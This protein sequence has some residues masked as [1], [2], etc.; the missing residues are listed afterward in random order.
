MESRTYPR[1][2]SAKQEAKET[3]STD[4]STRLHPLPL[5]PITH[6]LQE[7]ILQQPRDLKSD[8]IGLSE[9]TLSDELHNLGEIVFLLENLLDLVP[10]LDEPRLGRL[11]VG[12]EDLDVFRVGERPVDGGEVLSLGELPAGAKDEGER[13]GQFDGVQA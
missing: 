7:V 4:R 3:K 5:P 11:V 2:R 9:R 6:L 13:S 10:L 1:Y 12:L 8:L